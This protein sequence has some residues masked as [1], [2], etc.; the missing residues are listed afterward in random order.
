MRG[1]ASNYHL[2][3]NKKKW[4][5]GGYSILKIIQEVNAKAAKAEGRQ[6]AQNAVPQK[7]TQTPIYHG[8]LTF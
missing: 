3:C 7:N 6:G 4:C 1:G 2:P 5:V 8:W